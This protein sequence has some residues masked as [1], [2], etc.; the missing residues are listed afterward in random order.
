MAGTGSGPSFA[1]GT[2]SQGQGQGSIIPTGNQPN[3]PTPI[4][5]NAGTPPP[6]SLPA[7]NPNPA[8]P[9]SNP[10]TAS[11]GSAPAISVSA[12][13]QPQTPIQ[14]PNQPSV[15]T[16]ATANASIP[17]VAS[18]VEPESAAG[19][20]PSE[21]AGSSILSQIA[22]IMQ[23]NKSL[24]ILQTQSEANA[25]IPAAAQNVTN[26][27]SQQTA[28]QNQIAQLQNEATPGGALES[29]EQTEA[30]GRG[31]TTAGLAPMSAADQR[32]NEIQQSNL[33]GQ[34][35][36]LGSTIASA[37]GNLTL[38]KDLADK[39]AQVQ[40]DATQQEISYEQS[41]LASI[42]PYITAD[43]KAQADAVV[44][45]LADRTTQVN[46]AIANRSAAISEVGK[47]A[48]IAPASVLAQM[49]NASDAATV[50]QIAAANGLQVPTS[51]RYSSVQ[52]TTGYG[53]LDATTGQMVTGQPTYPTQAAANAAA[54][55]L[56]GGSAGTTG[57]YGTATS[58]ISSSTGINPDTPLSQVDPNA[59]ATALVSNEGGSYAGVE[60]NPGNIKFANLPGQS[61]SGVKAPDGGTYANY[62]T[63]AA[64]QA[65][66]VSDIQ[67]GVKNNPNQ[68]MGTFVD[69]YTNTAPQYDAA[70]GS[71][72][73][74]GVSAP[75]ALGTGTAKLPI[76]QYGLLANTDFNPTSTTDV[77]GPPGTPQGTIDTQALAYI[78]AYLQ[79]GSVP[80]P[81]V[82]GR[83]VKPG[84]FS[85]IQ[86]RAND[87]YFQ[88]TKTSLQ[89]QNP[90]ILASQQQLLSKNLG[91]QNTLDNQVG[92]IQKNFGLNLANMTANNV[93]QAPPIINGLVDSLSQALGYTSTAQYLAQNETIQNELG[94]LL[95]VKNQGG[96]TVADKISAG[97]LLPSDLSFAQQKQILT[98]LMQEAQN[99][100]DSIQATNKGIYQQID[101]LNMN[102]SNPAQQ[103]M[104]V[105]G[106]M[107]AQNIDYNTFLNNPPAGTPS[108]YIPVMDNA[109]GTFGWIDPT[110][111]N[112]STFTKA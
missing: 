5:Q 100:S 15:N 58:T 43:Q 95:A 11:G 86:N 105:E 108:S 97:D 4:D 50:D 55:N 84:L 62:S 53:V 94:T 37:Q 36:A 44:A 57:Q 96:T 29:A 65:A 22:G 26:L 68:T 103:Q 112:S 20:T 102:P 85:L 82:L 40:Y 81:S 42:Q 110:A 70:Q 77:P 35:L 3:V 39:A 21:Q 93:N 32:S 80:S 109:S 19:S 78:N 90:S 45:N 52:T 30:A 75:G 51:G 12:L 79:N 56:N 60:N 69:K 17:S 48:Q 7:V 88:A 6:S 41:L 18:A 9:I 73:A 13:S 34:N 74:I 27:T 67:A 107:D 89:G 1:G 25:G 23:G 111:Y 8:E 106:A 61:D 47:F 24:A 16:G 54:Q 10:L 104:R 2:N 98:T 28:I 76:A 87:L 33:V 59:L 83:N 63:K 91:L 46:A 101:P 92:T 31:I 99:Q 64:G 71:G 38:S 72:T 49:Q 14:P 66:I